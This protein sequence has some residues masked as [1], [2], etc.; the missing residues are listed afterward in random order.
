MIKIGVGTREDLVGFSNITSVFVLCL[1][2]RGDRV[3]EGF[4]I[5]DV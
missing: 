3:V 4:S 1:G 5:Y 2:L